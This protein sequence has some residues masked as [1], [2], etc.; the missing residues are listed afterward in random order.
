M[1]VSGEYI[2]DGPQQLVWETLLDPVVLASV[3]PG[4]EKLEL[5]GE[6]EYEGA[7]QIKVGPVQGKFL[8][9]V[10]LEDIQ[11]PDSYTMQ[12]DGRGGPGFVKATGHLK[13]SP[14][15]AQTNVDYEGDAQV[16]GRLASVG[17]R[18]VESS[19]KA[20]IKQSLAGLNAAVQARVARGGGTSEG[21]ADDAGSTPAPARPPSQ[22]EFAASVAKEVA[23]DLIPRWLMYSAGVA[24]VVLVLYLIYVLLT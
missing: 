13:L 23:K 2:F 7:L 5:I 20:I 21:G 12:V 18:L 8:G 1:K 11:A 24:A 22:R 14:A 19:A 17:Q 9:K 15:G 6:N 10:K 16:G 3:L 4:C